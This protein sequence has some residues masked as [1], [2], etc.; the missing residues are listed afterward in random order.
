MVEDVLLAYK[1]NSDL[2]LAPHNHPSFPYIP[3]A[4][5]HHDRTDSLFLTQFSVRLWTFDDLK[6]DLTVILF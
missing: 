4:H 2:K 3:L 6:T 5:R 1:A